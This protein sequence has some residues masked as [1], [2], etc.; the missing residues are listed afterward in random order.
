MAGHGGGWRK[1]PPELVERFESAMAARP[2]FSVRKMFGY[3]AGFASNGHMV[4]GLHQDSWI[5]RLPED[6]RAELS[7]AGGTP[8]E[9]M[10]GRPMRE[11][12]ALPPAVVDDP[13]S[14][15]AW[16]DRGLA[17]TESLPAKN[18]Q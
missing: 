7:A 14:L 4:T 1:A 2:G 12:L 16:L 5:L 11:Y 3:P 18:K 13:A 15:D 10:P 6:A 8:F 9:P 17:Y